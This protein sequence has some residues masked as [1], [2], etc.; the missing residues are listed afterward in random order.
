MNE[1]CETSDEAEQN[2]EAGISLIDFFFHF[3]PREF[4]QHLR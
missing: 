4:K 2:D 3:L 1:Q